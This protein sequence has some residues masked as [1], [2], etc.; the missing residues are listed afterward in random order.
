L[1]KD[2]SFVFISIEKKKPH[3]VQDIS[4]QLFKIQGFDKV[5]FVIF[6]DYP[7]DVNDIETAVWIFANNIEPMR[8]C[9]II[10][11]GTEKE[12]SHLVIDGTRKRADIDNFKRDWPDI[13]TADENTINLV[14]QKW[15]KYK[16]GE[17]IPSPSLKYKSLVLSKTA[18]VE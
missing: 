7:V 13:V 17:F 6:L 16:I 14:D 1:K 15:E 12:S 3:H 5:K 11:A 4:M 10:N 8:D 9:F 2:I 18:I